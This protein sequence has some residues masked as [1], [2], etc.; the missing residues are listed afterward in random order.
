MEDK[1]EICAWVGVDAN[2][3]LHSINGYKEEMEESEF[4]HAY[5][6]KNGETCVIYTT[7]WEDCPTETIKVTETPEEVES[8][9]KKA[10]IMKQK[11]FNEYEVVKK[12]DGL[13]NNY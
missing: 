9:F 3:T 6:N 1:I 8:L 5:T 12:K 13:R 7:G 10:R 4:V 2:V 11:A